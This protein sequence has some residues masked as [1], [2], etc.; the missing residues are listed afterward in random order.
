MKLSEYKHM[1]PVVS[2][3]TAFPHFVHLDDS[4]AKVAE[5]MDEHNIRHV[6]VKDGDHVVGIVSERD[7]RW[8]KNPVL[9]SV[10]VMTLKV[11]DLQTPDP[12]TVQINSP[13]AE[14]VLEMANRK[15]GTAVVVKGEKLA[16]I[17]TVI[18]V[19][20]ALGEFLTDRFGSPEG[21]QAA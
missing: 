14:V 16:G 10:D 12:Y 7:L 8:V 17:V 3:M 19:C 5:L 15:I 2:V 18:D 4:I 11:R 9:P 21:G 20:R 1:P 13:L 6:P